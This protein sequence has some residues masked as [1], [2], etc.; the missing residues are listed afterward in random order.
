MNEL[1]P[2][3]DIKRAEYNPRVM[4]DSEMNAL[5]KSLKT[6]GFVEP[7][8]INTHLGREGILVGGHQ[9]TSA[10]EKLI[11]AGTPPRGVTEKGGQ[12][13]LP[14]MLVDLDEEQERALNLALNKIH[15]KWDENKLA[16]IIVGL[17]DSDVMPATGFRDD[18]V[19]R[20]LDAAFP[21][22]E[23]DSSEGDGEA[24]EPRSKVGEIYDLGPHRLIC[25]DATDP[26]VLDALLGGA[27]AAMVWTDPPYNVNYKAKG[28]ALAGEGKESLKN[29][30]MTPEDFRKLIEGAFAAMYAETEPGG[31]FYICSGWQSYITF[32]EAML[33]LGFYHSSVITWVKPSA[34]QGYADYKHRTEIIA[35]AKKADN[36]T[37]E[38]IIYGW[39]EGTHRFFGEN[40]MDVWEMPRKSVQHYLHPTEKPDWLP[41]RAIRNSSKRG[42]IVLDPFAG[43]GSVMAAAHKTG[44]R[45]YMVELDP[46]FCDA[47]RDRW[48][49]IE[50]AEAEH[51]AG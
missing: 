1:Y 18:E 20:I 2:L 31:A 26:Y 32:V 8:V 41:M 16:E 5:E 35:K 30:H 12:W 19:S 46:K 3:A 50:K 7:V 39:K 29:D 4:P 22:D 47:I 48:E 45:A 42:E 23:S 17:K 51:H 43:S 37:A 24:K 27:K 9:R 38:A 34:V 10:T 6:F 36:K 21:D 11:I 15:G 28:K 13:F 49:R 25:G 44:R 40:E 14:A 33:K